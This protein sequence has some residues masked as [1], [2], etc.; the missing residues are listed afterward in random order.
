MKALD[1]PFVRPWNIGRDK[2][3]E[4]VYIFIIIYETFKTLNTKQVFN[5]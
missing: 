4:Q 2:E 5:V 3:F 1:R